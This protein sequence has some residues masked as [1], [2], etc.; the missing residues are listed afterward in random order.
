MISTHHRKQRPAVT[1][2]RTNAS[3]HRSSSRALE[4]EHSSP[5]S[6]AVEGQQPS[7]LA[8]F[9]LP[10]HHQLPIP[11]LPSFLLLLQTQEPPPWPPQ[12]NQLA[13]S[14]TKKADSSSTASR[15]NPSSLS[16]TVRRLDPATGDGRG[17]KRIG[18][19]RCRVVAW[20]ERKW[21]VGRRGRWRERWEGEEQRREAER[22]GRIL[23]FEARWA[24]GLKWWRE[25]VEFR[26]LSRLV[27]SRR[28]RCRRGVGRGSWLVS[29]EE[30]RREKI[31]F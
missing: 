18:R 26:N 2:P 5:F 29:L 9:L 6:P 1:P 16:T 30:G 7:D 25:K 10:S 14:S 8:L 4:A 3:S 27:R 17:K 13:S 22:R 23:G 31:S 28:C 11:D 15:S 21:V 20:L 19:R 24:V 12:V